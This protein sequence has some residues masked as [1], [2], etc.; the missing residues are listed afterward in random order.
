VALRLKEL[1]EPAVKPAP[2]LLALFLLASCGGE[3]SK[4]SV[5]GALPG[6]VKAGESIAMPKELESVPLPNGSVIDGTRED[7]AGN[8]IFQGYVPGDVRGARD[9]FEANLPQAGYEVGE[10]DSEDHEAEMEFDGHGTEARLKV[11]DVA[12]CDGA[13]TLE[14][15]E[16]GQG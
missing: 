1:M 9:Y 8:T 3:R 11:H 2:F 5:G 15:A 10:G 13:L 7:A 16:K 4:G 14:L 12:T 6:C